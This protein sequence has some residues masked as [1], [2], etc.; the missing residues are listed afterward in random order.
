MFPKENYNSSPFFLNEF[1]ENHAYNGIL[2]LHKT[3][4]Q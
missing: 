4:Q 3:Y 2:D 1:A